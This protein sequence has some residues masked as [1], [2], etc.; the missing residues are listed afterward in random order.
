MHSLRSITFVLLSLLPAVYLDAAGLVHHVP[1]DGTAVVFD[2]QQTG[3]VIAEGKDF[4]ISSKGTIRLAVVGTQEVAGLKC[5]WIE[6]ELKQTA[7]FGETSTP[8]TIFDYWKVL[9]PQRDL[10]A[11]KDL[12]STALRSIPR[13]TG[14]PN[15]P[16]LS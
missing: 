1:A 6:I 9:M 15:R 10:T 16:A 11:D 4:P 14:R 5:R 3:T 2:F 13:T 8:T 12:E 7:K